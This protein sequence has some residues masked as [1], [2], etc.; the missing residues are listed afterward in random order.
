MPI[1]IRLTVLG[2]PG[3]ASAEAER[4]VDVQVTAPADT[5]L[6]AVL[7]G[8]A[9]AVSPG[10][11]APGAVFCEDRQLHPHRSL[12]GQPPLVDGAVLAFHGPLPGISAPGEVPAR[13]LVVAGPDAGGVHL[14][15]G[16]EVRIGRS[17]EADVPLDDPDVS[18]LH[19]AVAVAADG[20]VT[21]T[22]LGSTNGT[23]LDGAP[24]P[25]GSPEALPAGALLR[26][27]ESVLRVVTEAGRAAPPAAG[28]P[29]AGEPGPGPGPGAAAGAGRSDRGAAASGDSGASGAP[30]VSGTS[31][32]P[33]GRGRRAGRRRLVS[34]PWSPLRG[35]PDRPGEEADA[36]VHGQG[37]AALGQFGE[38]LEESPWPDPATVLLTALEPGPRLW[39]RGAGHPEALVV[40]LGTEPRSSGALPAVTVRLAEAGALGLAG[41][42][43]RLTALARC[44]L[45]QLAVLH[46]PSALELV[47]LAPGRA[48]AW[49][50]PGWLPHLRPGRGQEC[51]LLTAFD[52]EQAAAR[53]RELAARPAPA[54]P[55]RRSVVLVDGEPGDAGLR[56][57][58]ARLAA[59]GSVAG[60]HLIC[61]A[62]APPATAASPVAATLA[63]ARESSAAFASCG[64]VA[65][66][67]G[68]V[69][70]AMRLVGP[71]GEQGR[72]AIADAVS[73]AWAERLARALAPLREQSPEAS[74]ASPGGQ[75]A[76]PAVAGPLPESCRLLDV[77]ELPRVTPGALRERWAR[78]TGPSLVLG[79]G[80]EGPVAAD[81][82]AL[83][84]P[85]TVTG[86]PGS[87]RTEL[88][89]S[90][91][92]SL[93]VAQSPREL[94]L[95]LVEG[96]G[97]GLRPCAELPHVAS[98]L[99]ATDPV[100]MRAFAQALREELKRRAGL[101]G[102]GAF[103]SARLRAGRVV[104][105]RQS[106]EDAPPSPVPESPAMRAGGS[107][108]LP[109]LVLLVDDVDA[110]A[111][112]PLG[113]PG[114]QAAGSV[115][116][117][118]EAVAGEGPRLGVHL[119]TAGSATDRPAAAQVALA[120]RPAGR[121]ELR[122]GD[123]P[124][125][126]FQAAR[127]TGR[128][129]RTATLRPTVVRLDWERAGDPPTRRPVRE[130]GNG[131]TDVALL[132]S[133]ASRAA[134]SGQSTAATL[135]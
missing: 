8:L 48:S 73:P 110:L 132:A 2:R 40:R 15:R 93:A 4:G 18:R 5:P 62:E 106:G 76:L 26:L 59:G 47:L 119:V 46:P 109:R 97:E 74:P 33:G 58:L 104:P 135:V 67:T 120:G 91:A 103:G 66:L 23:L 127:V 19:C 27:G 12:L 65:L 37:V 95:L 81:L 124:A 57:E 28:A 3:R 108:P 87:G 14:L 25:A 114:R 34:L 134:Q 36:P 115:M 107:G 86:D 90:L 45:A 111:A 43:D 11:A 51:R 44:L 16:G 42:R 22:D 96:S 126:A 105:P 7:G 92:A 125:V 32:D 99:G 61:L 122:R 113:A 30:A 121:A 17:A 83:P 64:T 1:Q 85:L 79:A 60:I 9:S 84:G 102:E 10:A 88:L 130:L 116:R 21:V 53:I 77:L 54:G 117:A 24:V 133:A 89:C 50:W 128:I 98:Y 63:A 80:A 75:G 39:E 129:P 68:P 13:L 35:R 20:S 78:S 6:S 94:S 101:L 100:R 31:G 49:S 69:A 112:P 131:P 71:G 38:T 41:P 70:T 118:L 56:Q 55:G 29:A 72:A 123:E 52:E 82:A